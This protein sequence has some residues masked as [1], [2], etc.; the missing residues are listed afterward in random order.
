MRIYFPLNA[1]EISTLLESKHLDFTNQLA[2]SVTSEMSKLLELTDQDELTL[3]AALTAA[4]LAQEPSAIAVLETDVTVGDAE[5]G[6]V[7]FTQLVVLADLECW[8]IPD[9]ETDQVSW[10]GIQETET[11][12]EQVKNLAP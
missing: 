12:L 11:V 5:L 8:L 1:T 6:E 4:D 3:I 7:F 9:L 2:V 10:F